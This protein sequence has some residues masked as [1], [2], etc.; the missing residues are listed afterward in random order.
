M[1]LRL[2]GRSMHHVALTEAGATFL[3]HVRRALTKAE[4]AFVEM[5]DAPA[6]R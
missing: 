5:S 1:R 4:N 6:S 3:P 2:F